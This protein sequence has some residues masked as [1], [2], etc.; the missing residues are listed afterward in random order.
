[1]RTVA[2]A[3]AELLRGGVDDVLGGRLDA[4][5]SKSCLPAAASEPVEADAA[6]QEAD[7]SQHQSD[8]GGD[9]GG[10]RRAHVIRGRG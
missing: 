4:A 10:A 2:L 1:M 9:H 7:L 5:R 3:D 6:Q 8:A